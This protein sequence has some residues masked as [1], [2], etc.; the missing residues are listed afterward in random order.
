MDSVRVALQPCRGHGHLRASLDGD[1]RIATLCEL[2]KCTPALLP[3]SGPARHI[4]ESAM[5]ALWPNLCKLSFSSLDG[6]TVTQAIWPPLCISVCRFFVVGICFPRARSRKLSSPSLSSSFNL[7][8]Y[9]LLA[10][11]AFRVGE[12]GPQQLRA[13]ATPRVHV[14]FLVLITGDH[15]GRHKAEC[16]DYWAIARGRCYFFSQ[17]HMSRL[18]G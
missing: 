4:C 7:C 2:L 16:R 15:S 13:C 18:L 6:R 1:L 17:R 8:V 3:T 9:L 12:A 10:C 14:L 11:S 5:Q